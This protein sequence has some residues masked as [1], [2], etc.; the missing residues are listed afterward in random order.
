MAFREYFVYLLTNKSNTVLYV[1]VTN[2]LPRRLE[3]HRQGLIKGFTSRYKTNKLVHY[4]ITNDIFSAITREKV[5]KGWL[6]CKKEDL[7]SE[8][9]PNWRD[10]SKDIY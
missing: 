10:L 2:N 6:R 1:G 8:N 3:E 7:V 4:E 5:L 9:N